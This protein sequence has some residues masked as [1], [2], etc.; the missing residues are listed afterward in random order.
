MGK[1]L[2]LLTILDPALRGVL[3]ISLGA[4]PGALSRYYLTL[5]FT[6]WLGNSFP[7]STFIINITGAMVMGCFVTFTLERTITSP[8]LRLLISV[9]FLG[10]YTTFSTYA[11][12]TD[13][14]LRTG[15][16]GLALLYG[17]GSAVMGVLSLE[18]GS[19]IARKL[20]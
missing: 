17:V 6:R 18:L 1:L 20:P 5:F 10:S 16:Q 12:E 14:L 19:F 8:E 9:G 7:Y 4:V 2:G 11:L 15:H 13:H 3:A